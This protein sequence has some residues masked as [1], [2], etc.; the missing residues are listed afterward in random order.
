MAINNQPRRKASEETSL[1]GTLI[2]DLQPE[3]LGGHKF[4]FNSITRPWHL[5][6]ASAQTGMEKMREGTKN[7]MVLCWWDELHWFFFF[8]EKNLGLSKSMIKTPEAWWEASRYKEV[9]E[10]QKPSENIREVSRPLGHVWEDRAFSGLPGW[11]KRQHRIQE[12]KAVSWAQR[13]C[14]WPEHVLLVGPRGKSGP[15]GG[16]L[17]P[18]HCS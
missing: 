9:P 14:L 7:Q 5:S 2:L 1:Q 4:L 15:Q 12:R 3:E 18:W 8:S 16:L 13:R 11:V 10:S 6:W 17:I